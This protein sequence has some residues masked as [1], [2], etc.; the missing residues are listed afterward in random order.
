MYNVKLLLEFD[1]T[2]YS[3]WLKQSNEEI[4]TVQRTVEKAV[5]ELVDIALNENN[6][7]YLC[8]WYSTPDARRVYEK[9]GFKEVGDYA[10]FHK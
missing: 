9:L 1:G 3:G 5:S 8:L 2:K 4:V 6:I 7:G 10:Y